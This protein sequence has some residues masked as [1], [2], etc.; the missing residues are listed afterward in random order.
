VQQGAATA[1]RFFHLWGVQPP[2]ESMPVFVF[3]VTPD[4]LGTGVLQPFSKTVWQMCHH[5]GYLDPNHC[6]LF[7]ICQQIFEDYAAV[8]HQNF[9]Y[10][11]L[12]YCVCMAN[13]AKF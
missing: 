1:G 12:N 2:Q 4:P 3:A 8:R 6:I 13:F 9:C 11:C 5:I 10:I 7:D